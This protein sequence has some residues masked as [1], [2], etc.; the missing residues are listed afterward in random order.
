MGGFAGPR[1][2]C[3]LQVVSLFW[4]MAV[5]TFLKQGDVEAGEFFW[6]GLQN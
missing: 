6:A 1:E 5:H 2:V 3:M 4:W